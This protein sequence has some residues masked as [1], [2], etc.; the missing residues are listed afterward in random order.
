[1]EWGPADHSWIVIR[2]RNGQAVD[3]NEADWAV[4]MK[5]AVRFGEELVLTE[6]GDRFA[7]GK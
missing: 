6:A 2:I 3:S 5:Y 4:R 1:M 7:D